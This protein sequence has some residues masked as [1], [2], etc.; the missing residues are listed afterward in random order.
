MPQVSYLHML[1]NNSYSDELV[2]EEEMNLKY[3]VWTERMPV[4][5]TEKNII[6][7]KVCIVSH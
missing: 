6:F 3:S 1:R 2:A 7:L 5:Y 4:T